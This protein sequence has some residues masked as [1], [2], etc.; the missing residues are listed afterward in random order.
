MKQLGLKTKYPQNYIIRR[1][2]IGAFVLFAFSFGFTL[3]YHPLD[4]HA[5]FYFDFELTMLFYTFTSSVIGGLTIFLLKKIPYFSKVEQWTIGRE[6]LA[7]YLILQFMGIAIYLLAF[8]FEPPAVESRWN[9]N[10]FWD[11]CKYSFLIYIFPFA[12]FSAV[13]YKFLL[14]EFE[15]TNSE[16]IEGEPH[17]QEVQIRSKLKKESLT[18][19]ASQMLFAVSDGNYVVFHLQKEDGIKKVPIRNSISEIEGQ[20]EAFPYF[21]RSHRGFIVNLNKVRSKKGN[22]SGYLLKI[23]GSSDVIPVSRKNTEKFDQAMQTPRN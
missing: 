6:L 8:V 19:A 18:F 23:E 21:F 14:L 17:E 20:L 13:N 5:S 3:L 2:V 1:P 10:T 22:S 11:S 12:F 16:V 15:S 7:V 9:L 4:T